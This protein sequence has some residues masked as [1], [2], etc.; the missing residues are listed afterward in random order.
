MFNVDRINP[1]ERK[2]LKVY[3]IKGISTD[4]KGCNSECR[5]DKAGTKYKVRGL[6][7]VRVY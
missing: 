4:G 1:T 3:K 5:F 2:K 6:L 7:N